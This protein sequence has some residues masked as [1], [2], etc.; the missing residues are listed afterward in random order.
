MFGLSEQYSDIWG[1]GVE[2]PLFHIHSIRIK[3][4]DIK[5]L[6]NGSTIKFNYKGLDFIK[7]FCS[8]EF[9]EK[10]HIGKNMNLEIEVIGELNINIWGNKKTKQVII[11]DMEVKEYEQ[12][13]DDLF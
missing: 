13:I 3:G 4:S 10:L 11:Q 6:G 5:E 12:G 1:K 2:K 9:K 7:F 8:K